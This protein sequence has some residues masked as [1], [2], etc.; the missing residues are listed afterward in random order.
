MLSLLDLNLQIIDK[1]FR[2]NQTIL[3]LLN[4]AILVLLT[5][6]PINSKLTRQ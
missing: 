4:G 3:I 5:K 1:N 6:Q 2:I